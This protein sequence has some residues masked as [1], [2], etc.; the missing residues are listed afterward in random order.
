MARACRDCSSFFTNRFGRVR[1]RA[2]ARY[3]SATAIVNGT[4]RFL[5]SQVLESLALTDKPIARDLWPLPNEEK[6]VPE[7]E[8]ASVGS[9]VRLYERGALRLS[10]F[11][12]QSLQTRPATFHGD[13]ASAGAVCGTST[14][15]VLMMQ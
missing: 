7:F 6:Q 5:G 2:P 10:A 8:T 12:R 11:R 3:S 15:V 14:S 1:S 13:R 4:F 9:V